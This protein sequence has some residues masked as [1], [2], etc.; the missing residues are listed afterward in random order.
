MC[1]SCWRW[2]C[3]WHGRMDKDQKLGQM[4]KYQE[5]LLLKYVALHGLHD[6]HGANIDLIICFCLHPHTAQFKDTKGQ[7]W[8]RFSVALCW[9]LISDPPRPP[10]QRWPSDSGDMIILRLHRLSRPPLSGEPN[11]SQV[12]VDPICTKGLISPFFPPDSVVGI[13]FGLV[14]QDK[15]RTLRRVSH[16]KEWWRSSHLKLVPSATL[17]RVSTCLAQANTGAYKCF[18]CIDVTYFPRLTW[19]S[20]QIKEF[21]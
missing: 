10:L 6:L 18:H 11:S 16:C 3:V 8:F 21:L 4:D 12:A 2:V 14:L 13:A 20:E 17:S 15:E 9:Y 7:D 1:R 5:R 19:I